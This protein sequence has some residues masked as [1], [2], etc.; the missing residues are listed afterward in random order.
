MLAD[1]IAEVTGAP[2]PAPTILA[3]RLPELL[4]AAGLHHTGSRTVRWL[5]LMLSAQALWD[6]LL[7]S[8]VAAAAT[9][10]SATP[11]TQYHIHEQFLALATSLTDSGGT[12][13]LPVGAI[14][15]TAQRRPADRSRRCRGYRPSAAHDHRP[16]PGMS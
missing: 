16:R 8:P 10:L 6:G 12:A 11:A 13:R 14:I 1:A 4:H 2:A 3:G 7:A 15:A 9:V 5:H